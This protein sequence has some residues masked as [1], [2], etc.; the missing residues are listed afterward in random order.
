MESAMMMDGLRA[1]REWEDGGGLGW[2]G[3]VD[4]LVGFDGISQWHGMV[5]EGWATIYVAG[6]LMS[7]AVMEGR[8]GGMGAS[9]DCETTIT[10]DMTRE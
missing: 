3:Q 1:V 7:C 5:H 6:D 2:D 9:N 4:G 8:D 10:N